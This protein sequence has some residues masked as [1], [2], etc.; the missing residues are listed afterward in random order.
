V[1]HPLEGARLRLDRA[2]WHMD[3]LDQTFRSYLAT[4][5]FEHHPEFPNSPWKFEVVEDPITATFPVILGEAIQNMRTAL[6]YL[7]YELVIHTRGRK[8]RN[9]TQFPLNVA[10]SEF[11]RRRYQISELPGE[12]R[13]RIRKLQPYQTKHPRI[14]PL[15]VLGRLSNTDKHRLLLTTVH[16][17]GAIS[18][19]LKGSPTGP[20]IVGTQA[21]A[22]PHYLQGTEA[23][24]EIKSRYPDLGGITW[25]DLGIAGEGDESAFAILK[26]LLWTVTEIIDGFVP[27]FGQK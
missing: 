22:I 24:E 18:M 3:E 5:Q 7:V 10:A 6:D 9:P 12:L 16:R 15:A 13:R 21:V 1:S 11:F 19:N 26:R 17:I 25:L 14:H 4:I 8:P 23:A 2:K 27:V 20:V